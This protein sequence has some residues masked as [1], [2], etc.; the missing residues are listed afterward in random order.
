MG[1]SLSGVSLPS[2][3]DGVAGLLDHA[4]LHPTATGDELVSQ[5][6]GL[7]GYPLASVC[8]RPC[9]VAESVRRIE[10]TRIG[11]VCTVIGF[12]HGTTSTAA[13]VAESERAMEEG[14]LELDMV[15]NVARVLSGDWAGVRE[16]IEAVRRVSSDRGVLLKVIFETGYVTEARAKIE[17]CR[18]C[19]DVG[20]DFVKTS[21]GFGFVKGVDGS[22][23]A[24]GASEEDVS[25]MRAHAGA[26]VGVKPSGGIRTLDAV[27][28]YVDLGATRIGT[29]SSAGILR[30]AESRFAEP[31]RGAASSAGRAEDERGY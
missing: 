3:V 14:A 25:L 1:D 28:R 17:L 2:S 22:V 10:G 9:D 18:Q 23:R 16:D 31:A 26:S 5:I 30:E 15:V 11:C 6:D 4:V 12:P 21:T 13:K 27:L 20:V 29:G 8:V 19:G 24:T 7:G